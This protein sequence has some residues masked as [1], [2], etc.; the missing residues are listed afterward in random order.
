MAK[1]LLITLST[2]AKGLLFDRPTAIQIF[3]FVRN[4]IISMELL[5]G[6]MISETSLAKQFG[7]SRTPVR[8]ALIQLSTI[9]F[10]EVLPQRGTYVTKFN[11]NKILE[12]RFIRE[13]IEVSVVSYL[14]ENV[15]DDII[16][17]GEK[18]IAEQKVAAD[19][20]DLVSFQ[21]LDDKFHQA[22]ANS[23]QYARVGQVI[24]AEK[25]HV[26]RV[27]CLSLQEEDQVKRV[28]AQHT[29]IIKAI[30]SGVPDKAAKA[31]SIH[32]KDVYNVLKVIPQEHPEYFV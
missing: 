5:P 6:Q 26:D 9:G 30:K 22:L 2:N 19:D 32:L 23:T 24:E 17:A 31:M 8:E 21:K 1:P 12:A 7:V 16:L 3:S 20:R 28:I 27:R 18:I 11:M 14:A 4:A 15:T 29:V 10:V 25:A 13:A